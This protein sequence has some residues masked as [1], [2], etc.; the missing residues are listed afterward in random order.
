MDTI[1]DMHRMAI[2]QI[3]SKDYYV[4]VFQKCASYNTEKVYN[5]M[6]EDQITSFWN[7]FWFSLPDTESIRREPFFLICDLAEG[8][9]VE[10][11]SYAG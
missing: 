1:V 7:K 3:Y 10:E 5:Y 8:S 6:D 4:E 2:G 9:L 11:Q